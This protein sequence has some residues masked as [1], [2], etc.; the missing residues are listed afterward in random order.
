[1]NTLLTALAAALIAAT[2]TSPALARPQAMPLFQPGQAPSRPMEVLRELTLEVGA[3][4]NQAKAV[5]QLRQ[6][7]R[8]LGADAVLDVVVE[9]KKD[10]AAAKLAAAPLVLL[11]SL[12]SLMAMSPRPLDDSVRA[13]QSARVKQNLRVVRG[14]A[15]KYVR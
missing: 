10:D 4:G 14:V 11:G 5:E 3:D 8:E 1:M 2:V 9:L 12:V 6:Q 15:V 7:A 13:A